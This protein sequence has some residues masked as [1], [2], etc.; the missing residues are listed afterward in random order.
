[1]GFYPTATIFKVHFSTAYP[2]E[3]LALLFPMISEGAQ[4]SP[5]LVMLESQAGCNSPVL[6]QVSHPALLSEMHEG[7]MACFTPLDGKRN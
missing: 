3:L 1:M 2:G 4:V 5:D 6:H 7:E